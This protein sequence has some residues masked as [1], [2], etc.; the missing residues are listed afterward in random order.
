MKKLFLLKV[1]FLFLG[2]YIP[3]TP[4]NAQFHIGSKIETSISAI[5]PSNQRIPYYSQRVGF[6]A[7]AFT[8]LELSPLF[9]LRSGLFYSLRGFNFGN[10]P[11]PYNKDKFWNLHGLNIPL[12][13]VFKL[14][15][16]IQIAAGLDMNAVLASNLPVISVPSLQLGIR[17]ECGFNLTERLRVAAYY[18]HGFNKLLVIRTNRPSQNGYYNNIMAG[19]SMSYILKTVGKKEKIPIEICP[20]FL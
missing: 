1:L 17:G 8:A 6:R 20:S 16:Q 9:D 14:N 13:V 11:N 7:G 19:I 12:L 2:I 4:L 3:H 18:M 15:E 5:V 10:T